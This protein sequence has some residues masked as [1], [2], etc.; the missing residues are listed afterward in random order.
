M[1]TTVDIRAVD[2]PFN[3]IVPNYNYG[4]IN[5]IRIGT[6]GRK[7]LLRYDLSGIASDKICTA[8]T[9]KFTNQIDVPAEMNFYVYEIAAANGDWVEGTGNASAQ[10][11]SPCWNK[12]VY[13]TTDWAGSAGLSTA[14]TDYVNTALATKTLT[15][16]SKNTDLVEFTVNASGLAILQGWFGDASNAGFLLL[17]DHASSYHVFHS[18][19]S[20]TA[21]Y[22]PILSVTYDDPVT[23][24]LLKVNF[25][26]QMQNL[27]GNMRG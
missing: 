10:N 14:G 12:K 7:S 15:T 26:A 5:I 8:A 2:S 11:G 25:N 22:R 24:N 1:A 16:A 6:G 19:E 9:F 4:S 21:G 18:K 17:S 3:S 13:N 27:S 23:G 20:T